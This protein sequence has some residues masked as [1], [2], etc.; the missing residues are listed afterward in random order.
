MRRWIKFT[1]AGTAGFAVQVA[2]LAALT[3]IAG[4]HYLIATD[5]ASRG[6]DVVGITHVVNYDLPMDIENYVHRIGRTGRIGKD[7]VAISFVTPEQGGHLTEIEKTINKL[8]D[9]D[10]IEGFEAYTSRRR[11]VSE[12]TE[13][14]GVDTDTPPP[15]RKPVYGKFVRRHSN[16]L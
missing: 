12:P 3:Q 13:G 11:S 4:L 14:A 6:I 5:V 16:R 2:A 9:E 7:G 10:R 8:I 1:L 15:P